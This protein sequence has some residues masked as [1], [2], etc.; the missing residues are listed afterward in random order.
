MIALDGFEEA[1]IGKLRR[2]GQE[3]ILVYDYDKCVLIVMANFNCTY[4]DA[5]DYVEYNVVN[6]WMGDSTPGFLEREEFSNG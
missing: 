4:D 2:C 1:V 5:V 3:D 6:G